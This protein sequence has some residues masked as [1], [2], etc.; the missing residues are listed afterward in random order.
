[1]SDANGPHGAAAGEKKPD[2]TAFYASSRRSLLTRSITMRTTWTQSI[3]LAAAL[4]CGAATTSFAQDGI[5]VL[6]F[7]NSSRGGVTTSLTGTGK[8]RRGVTS[9]VVIVKNLVDLVPDAQINVSGGGSLASGI[10]HGHTS[11]GEGFISMKVAVPAGQAINS[12]ITINVGLLDHFNFS[13]V[14]RAQISAVSFNP[15]PT[16]VQGGTPFVLTITGTDFGTPTLTLAGTACHSTSSITQAATTFSATLQRLSTCTSLGPF[17]FTLSSTA[18]GEPGFYAEGNGT[19]SFTFGPYVAP[20]PTGVACV[21]AP[22]IG[23]PVIT[24]PVNNSAISFFTASGSPQTVTI[25][26]SRTTANNVEAPGNEWL[27]TVPT[28]K[29]GFTESLDIVGTSISP[30]LAVPGTYSVS[31]R[32]KNCGTSAPAAN[33]TFSL[34]FQ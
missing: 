4:L 9:T 30:R 20:A 16:T 22:N 19:F 17:G 6:D 32:A 28:A 10:T 1:V 14:H 7:S 21:S 5:T 29:V 26:W 25:T 34:K 15:N 23:A 12:T 11:A 24:N 31:V 18:S 2:R 13:T 33:V 3:A 8:L 27:V